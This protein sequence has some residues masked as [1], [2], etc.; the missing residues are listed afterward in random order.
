MPARRQLSTF[1]FC[2]AA[3]AAPATAAPTDAAPTDVEFLRARLVSHYPSLD[4]VDRYRQ[5]YPADVQSGVPLWHAGAMPALADTRALADALSLLQDQHVALAGAQAGAPETPGVLFRTASDGSMSV[6]RHIDD[7]VTQVKDGEQVLAIDGQPAARWLEQAAA[8]TFGGNPRSRMAEAALKLGVGTPADHALGG[9]GK[10]LHLTLRGRDGVSYS[11]ALDY[12]PMGKVGGAALAQALE[13]ADL[14]PLVDAHGYRVGIVRFGAFASQY[15]RDF[16]AAV[17]AAEASGANGDGPM[18]AG[19]CAVVRKRLAQVDALAAR[20]DLLL[21]DLRGNFGGFAREARL[22]ARALTPNPLPRTFDVVRGSTPGRLKLVAQPEDPS[23]GTIAHPR[24]LVVWTD[25]GTRSGGEFMAAW[26]W[27]AGAVTAGE[28][29]IGAGGGL[30]SADTGF[31]LPVSGMGVRFSE[32]FNVL[33]NGTVL[34]EG[35]IDEAGL[36]DLVARD[37]FAPSRTRPFG[38]QAVGVRPDLA[39]PTTAADLAD[40][41]AAAVQRIVAGLAAK[42]L[43][44][45]RT[46]EQAPESAH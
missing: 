13:R 18:L 29:T 15:D 46:V 28:R 17:E 24:P 3:I 39:L 6:W 9:V 37:G 42:G 14:P 21:V 19:F 10:T 22:L 8:H 2:L 11:V 31:V 4:W 5:A 40:G 38:F 36:L 20:A 44:A 12:R 45:R 1:A 26:L 41:G 25:A 34:R 32:N 35:E 33:D 43:L 16:K 7:N 27:A 30:D 23:C